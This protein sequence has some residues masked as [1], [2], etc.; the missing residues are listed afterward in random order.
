[1]KTCKSLIILAVVA[2]TTSIAWAQDESAYPEQLDT[3]AKR[4]SYMVGMDMGRSLTSL[5]TEL[6]LDLVIQAMR[7]TVAGNELLLTQEQAA[8]IKKSFIQERRQKMA[9]A[10]KAKAE[11]ASAENRAAGKAFLAENAG[12]E[13]VQVTESGLQYKVVEAGTGIS[14]D[15]ND[16]VTVHYVGTLIDGTV[17]DSSRERGQ[18]ATFGLNQVIPGW[19]EGLQLMKEGGRVT[20]FIPADLAYGDRAAGN[21]I[22]PGST[23]L[24]DVELLKVE[25][26]EAD[27]A[28]SGEQGADTEQDS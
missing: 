4:L 7:D 15:A 9:A 23:L 26:V 18:P 20:F 27:S 22:E 8:G 19:T 28:E 10:A 5:D 6:S 24:F 13:G 1:M 21:V 17:F 3:E 12:K 2:L 25:P 16:R 14:P 11:T